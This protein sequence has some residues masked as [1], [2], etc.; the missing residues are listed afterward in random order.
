VSDT[1]VP[2]VQTQFGKDAGSSEFVVGIVVMCAFVAMLA[3]VG[4]WMHK[5]RS[6]EMAEMR[7]EM[8]RQKE[9]VNS[10]TSEHAYMLDTFSSPISTRPDTPEV[11]SSTARVEPIIY[12]NVTAPGNLRDDVPE[13][14]ADPYIA[15]DVSGIDEPAN[16]AAPRTVFKDSFREELKQESVK[17][18]PALGQN[19]SDEYV[20]GFPGQDD[21]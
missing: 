8:R 3:A 18:V 13:E 15:V 14:A 10:V 16:S 9:V 5:R 19:G 11:S 12:D 20:G 6:R 21:S 17:R 7:T 1:G 2:D 4:V